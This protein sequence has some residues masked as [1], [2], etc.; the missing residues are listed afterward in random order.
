MKKS[1]IAAVTLASAMLFTTVAGVTGCNGKNGG[2]KA[3][4]QN[5]VVQ[6][7]EDALWFNYSVK[8]LVAGDATEYEY[9]YM[10]TNL[11]VTDDGYITTFECYPK[12]ADGME[13]YVVEFNKDGEL[14][15]KKQ[16]SAKDL[17]VQDGTEVYIN[18][19]ATRN[20]EP[21]ASINTF[22]F[23]EKTFEYSS[24]TILYNLKTNKVETIDYLTEKMGNGSSVNSMGFLDDGYEYIIEY[25]PTSEYGDYAIHLGKD[26]KFLKSFEI[27]KIIKDNTWGVSDP[28]MVNGVLKFNVYGDNSDL[29]LCIDTN[30]N[31]ATST[32]PWSYD[33]SDNAFIGSDGKSYHS[34][35]DG[36]YCGEELIMPFNATYVNPNK[37]SYSSILDANS[38]HFVLIST[39]WSMDQSKTFIY[40]FDKAD[41]N[42]NVGKDIITVGMVGYPNDSIGDAISS[43]NE[44]SDEYFIQTM[45]YTLEYNEE[46]YE[47]SENWSED[48]YAQKSYELTSAVT[49]ELAID[50][51]NGEGPD[52]LVNAMGVPQLN[53][54]EYLL[55]MSSFVSD[56][57]GSIEMFDNVI[58]ACKTD[59]KLYQI[60]VSFGV[61]GIITET[62]NVKGDKGFTFD[63]YA[64]F[65]D[66]VCN[67]SNPIAMYRSRMEVFTTCLASMSDQFYDEDGNVDFKNDAFYQLAEYCRDNVPE[68][69]D[70]EAYEDV[71]TWGGGVG[72]SYY[73]DSENSFTQLYGMDQYM[74]A[75]QGTKTVGLYGIPSIDGRGPSIN[76]DS[77]IAISAAV[78]NEE[79]AKSFVKFFFET[80][81]LFTNIYSNPISVSAAKANAKASLERNNHNF[82]SALQWS[83]E[84]EL[85]SWGEFK[86][87]ESVIDE[88][89][90]ILKNADNVS[91]MDMNIALII[92]EEIPAYFAG[93]KSIEEVADSIQKRAQTVIDERG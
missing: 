79:A 1:K 41:T 77:S 60:P 59:G 84:A 45:N 70:Y 11:T 36:I 42:P 81:D 5:E 61:A 27:S 12:G 14:I 76:V 47:G 8:E 30:D 62:K 19:I 7:E 43:F 83:S 49:N 66:E 85:N 15:S 33:E 92:Y 26:G 63:E 22:F 13:S 53:S 56:D 24:D 18:T 88:Y 55:D 29:D 23:D 82:E 58:E 87:D 86:Y 4:V 16:I 40:T 39:D 38:D 54:D 48:E 51:L 3:V 9:S 69:Y 67:G 50:M 34:S 65:V 10:N 90:S 74:S 57:L 21:V 71:V 46:D 72:Y 91:E 20:G 73:G 64:K 93:Q 6:V 31:L 78:S 75:K 25:I 28:R 89:I 44:S 35:N 68:E 32:E 52:I 37:V 2:S 17:G 80:D